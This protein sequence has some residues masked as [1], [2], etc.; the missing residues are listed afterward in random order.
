MAETGSIDP[1]DLDLL[2]F[3]DSVG[4]AVA[5]IERH[6]V[7]KFGLVRAVPRRIRILGE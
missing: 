4:E 7:E 6:A 2:V 1:K 3:T 5:H